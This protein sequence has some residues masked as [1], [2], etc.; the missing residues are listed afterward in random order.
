MRRA[1]LL[2]PLLVVLATSS[3]ARAT[4][5]LEKWWSGLDATS[6]VADAHGVLL[7][8]APIESRVRLPGGTFV[9][10]SSPAELDAAL[11]LC[12]REI[13]GVRFICEKLVTPLLWETAAHQV[14]L[15]PF[16][17]DRTEVSVAAYEKCVAASACSRA[18]FP[19]GDPHFDRPNLPVTF[20]SW[21]D[22][23][24]YCAFAGGRLPTEAEWEFTARGEKGRIFPWGNVFNSHLANR[25]AGI[26]NARDTDASDGY[27]FLAPVDAFRD[28]ATPEGVLQMAGNVSEWVADFFVSDIT[29]FG[30]ASAAVVNP[31]GPATGALHVARGGSYELG[32]V[33]LRTTARIPEWNVASDLGF[34]CAYDR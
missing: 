32:A 5:P 1:L 13:E 17:I 34:R 14:T 11:D 15:G 24:A 21:D 25:G 4:D 23:H 12:R 6:T 7:L 19:I 16:A 33:S 10:G 9:M 3:D 18:R 27:E 8:R 31:T 22:A 26:L 20:V 29:S 28:G 30:Y 2:A